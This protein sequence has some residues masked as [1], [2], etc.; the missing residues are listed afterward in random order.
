MAGSLDFD[1]HSAI[2]QY[3]QVSVGAGGTTLT[4]LQTHVA[5]TTTAAGTL[6]LPDP[7]R[8]KDEIVS[9]RFV[10]ATGICTVAFPGA[11]SPDLRLIVAGDYINAYSSGTHWSVI[12]SATNGGG[13]SE[14]GVTAQEFISGHCH[15]TVL[16]LSGVALVIG[17]NENLGVGAKLYTFPTGAI[18]I[19]EA[20]MSVGITLTTG[21]PTTDTPD[22]GL[23]TVIA[24]GAVAVLGGTSTFENLLTGQTA[25]D[26]AGTA[27]VKTIATQTLAIETAGVKAVFFN[28][29]DGWANVDNTAATLAGTV[30]LNWTHMF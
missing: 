18:V 11:G 28:A 24:S 6:T 30:V 13:T 23:G 1:R 21:T 16:T 7:S 25:A 10:S 29:A 26:V 3:E 2:T 4:P 12:A 14:T 15:Q 8:M 20:Y 22:V 9:I 17:D 19:Q 5:V 27:T